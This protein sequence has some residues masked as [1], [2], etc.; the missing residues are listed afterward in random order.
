MHSDNRNL[1]LNYDRNIIPS[2]FL[3]QCIPLEHCVKTTISE[4]LTYASFG[5]GGSHICMYSASAECC[6]DKRKWQRRVGDQ[7]ASECYPRI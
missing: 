4:F 3:S 5:G 6:I 2:P 7:S 1:A